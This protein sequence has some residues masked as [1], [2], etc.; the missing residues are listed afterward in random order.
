MN[1][2][3]GLL[4]SVENMKYAPSKPRMLA[5]FVG[6]I[7]LE[8]IISTKGKIPSN[9]ILDQ[10]LCSLGIVVVMT[11]M[12]SYCPIGIVGRLRYW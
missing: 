8:T 6:S 9:R 1:L 7:Y 5:F 12:V 4:F 2:G 10:K 11:R 3:H